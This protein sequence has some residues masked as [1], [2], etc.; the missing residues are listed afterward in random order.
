MQNNSALDANIWALRGPA[1][2]NL[3]RRGVA[4]C[5]FDKIFC[6]V[7][8][9]L[10]ISFLNNSCENCKPR[11]YRVTSNTR[12]VIYASQYF[13]KSILY[14]EKKLVAATAYIHT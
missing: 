6:H 9:I 14:H 2:V 5:S 12:F 7:S 3:D 1:G 10:I 8:T 4:F 11:V 13:V